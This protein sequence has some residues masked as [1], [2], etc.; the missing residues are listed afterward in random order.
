MSRD[1][2]S[3]DPRDARDNSPRTSVRRPRTSPPDTGNA[4]NIAA[5]N[6]DRS[7]AAHSREQGSVRDERNDSPRAYYVRTRAYLLHASE[8]HSLTEVGKFRIIAARDLAKH[9]YGGDRNTM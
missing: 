4:R 5:D 7:E 9:V 6:P 3:Y 2:F 1:A 8:I